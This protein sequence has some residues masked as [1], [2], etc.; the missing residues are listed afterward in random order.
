MAKKPP[1]KFILI[2]AAGYVAPRHMAAIKAVGGELVAAVD[3]CDSVGILD[4]Y[5]P[6]CLFFKDYLD[7]FESVAA[8]YAVICT[9]NNLHAVQAFQALEAGMDVIVEKPAAITSKWVDELMDAEKK[10]GK[11]VN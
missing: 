11:R 6:K 4:R 9:P 1:P 2:G 8:D 3:P 7:A 10:H 5:F